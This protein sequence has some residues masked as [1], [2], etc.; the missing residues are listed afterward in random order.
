MTLNLVYA[1]F[2]KYFGMFSIVFLGSFLVSPY[3]VGY[4]PGNALLSGS[5]LVGTYA[6]FSNSILAALNIK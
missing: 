6:V 1:D 4:L 3:L 5:F 2:Y